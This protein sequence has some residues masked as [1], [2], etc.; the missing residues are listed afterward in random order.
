MARIVGDGGEYRQATLFDQISRLD[1]ELTRLAAAVVL[2]GES[3]SLTAAIRTREAR[4]D[5]L[6][7]DIKMALPGA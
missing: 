2:G 1:T 3:R 6:D 5:E 7:A 4:R